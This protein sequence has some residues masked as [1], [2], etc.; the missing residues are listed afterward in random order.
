[1]IFNYHYIYE[2]SQDSTMKLIWKIQEM[3]SNFKWNMYFKIDMKHDYWKVTIHSKDR[4]YLIFHIFELNQLQSTKMSQNIRTSSF[5]F[6]KF[7]NIVLESISSS[8][9]KSSL[10][11]NADE[12]NSNTFFYIDDVF[13]EFVTWQNLYNF[14]KQHFFSRLIWIK[15]RIFFQKLRIE[16]LKI[17]CLKQMFKIEDSLNFKQK[18]INKILFWFVSQNQLEMKRYMNTINITRK[19]I[20]NFDEIIK[21]FQRFQSKIV[22]WKWTKLKDLTFITFKKFAINVM[23]MFDHDSNLFVETYIDV[24][25]WEIDIYIQQL[26]KNEMKSILFDSYNFMF[27]Q[28]NYDIYKKELFAIVHFIDKHEHFFNVKKIFTI[29]TNYKSF[30]D[31]LNAKKHEDIYARWINKL[32]MHNIKLKYIESENNVVANDLSRI[33]YNI[34]NCESNQ[35]VRNLYKKIKKHE[36][37]DEWFWKIDKDEYRDMFKKLTDENRKKRI[38]KYDDKIIAK[39]YHTISNY[40][41]E[42]SSTCFVECMTSNYERKQF[43]TCFVDWITFNKNISSIEVFSLKDTKDIFRVLLTTI[44]IDIESEIVKSNY[45]NDDWYSDFFKYY[46]WSQTFELNKTKMI[47]FKRKINIYRY[48]DTSER[49]LHK[50]K[51]DYCICIQKN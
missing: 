28:R 7:M 6:T 14:L 5:I 35:L 38:E 27:T 8:N 17:K 13:A 44:T 22:E 32:R 40:E 26:Q 49:L 43:S 11:H 45:I 12:S 25:K 24:S 21:S 50:Y 3:I 42:Q 16:I 20:L 9:S 18:S 34:E 4:H 10:L 37:D 30:V 47:A 1:M 41:E 36:N 19:W 33:I 29:H 46:V 48:Y 23:N 31:F 51:D 39:V 2:E 15:M